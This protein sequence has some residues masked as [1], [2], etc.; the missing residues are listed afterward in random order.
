M[1]KI[2]IKNNGTGDKTTGNCL[3]RQNDF[4]KF[5]NDLN[6]IMTKNVSTTE[7]EDDD[8]SLEESEN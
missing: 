1:R 5:M 2:A 3:I 4:E 6:D 8:E 7:D